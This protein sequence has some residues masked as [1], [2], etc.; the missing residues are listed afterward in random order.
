MKLTDLL[1]VSGMPGVFRLVANRKNGLILEDLDSGKRI[2]VPARG[3]QF[4]PM[5]TIAIYTDA[6][7]VELKVIFATMISQ[8][9]ENPPVLPSAGNDELRNYF[10]KILPEYD[11]DRV[12][13]SDIK[14][15]IK[16]FTFLHDRGLLK[17]EE[18]GT[19][20]AT[21]S[22]AADTEKDSEA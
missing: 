3:H 21:E 14:K 2:F 22:E 20:T 13:I 10:E 11:R 19:E 8:L 5:E 17:E 15:V 7:A 4:S 6:D 1:A 12:H 16:W 9:A 18:S